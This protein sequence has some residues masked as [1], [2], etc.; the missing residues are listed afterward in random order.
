MGL[1]KTLLAS[2]IAMGGF[3]YFIDS[4]AGS[5][6]N[7]GRSPA[8]AKQTLGSVTLTTGIKIGLARGSKWREQIGG[9][10]TLPDFV[11]IGAYGTGM[12]PAIDASDVSTGWTKTA[13]KTSVYQA[14]LPVSATGQFL[15]MYEN[16]VLL[17][18]VADTTAC[19]AAPGTYYCATTT[20]AATTTVFVNTSDS[21][22]PASNGKVYEHTNR[23]FGIMSN[24]ATGWTVTNIRTKRNLHTDGSLVLCVAGTARGCIAEDGGKHSIWVG[25]NGLAED[26][27]AHKT[28]YTDRTGSTMFISYTVNGVGKK[29]TYRRCVAL[30]DVAGQNVQGFFAHTSGPGSEWD[31]IRLEDC[32]ASGVSIGSSANNCTS[33]VNIRSFADNTVCGIQPSALTSTITDPYIKSGAQTQTSGVDMFGP[34]VIDGLRMYSTY[35]SFDVYLEAGAGVS[36]VSNSVC[37]SPDGVGGFF[38]LQTNTT[39]T[40]NSHHNIYHGAN[41]WGML[42]N[43]LGDSQSN[44]YSPNTPFDVA[45]GSYADFAAY[46]AA[47]PLLDVASITSDPLLIDPAN[48]NFGVSSG[49]P[50]IALGAG[51]LRP[52]VTYTTIPSGAA[53]A[54]M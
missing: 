30:Q 6:A 17:K 13:G 19:D 29:S 33:Y 14:D 9:Y 31:E 35:G 52:N 49:S 23:P 8:T 48:G 1:A 44:V 24:T 32:S 42:T 40:L 25:D 27:I 46:R 37:V 51:L 50:A 22:N 10:I 7:D 11:T 45:S 2:I 34:C 54:A 39:D 12:M 38:C 21:T 18:W 26:C 15:R 28:D 3:D 4:V 41:T 47:N 20:G 53:I 5:D 16:N 43:G 36:T